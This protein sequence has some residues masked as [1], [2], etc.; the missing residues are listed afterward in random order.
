MKRTYVLHPFL[1]AAYS[2]F[3]VY[4]ANLNQIPPGDLLRP[5]A[6]V[7]VLAG[8]LLGLFYL[9]KHDWHQAGLM[10]SVSVMA[11]LYFGHTTE[12]ISEAHAYVSSKG[13][14][15]QMLAGWIA[16][17][18]IMGMNRT[19][20]LI[21][22]GPNLTFYINI[23][24]LFT[25]IVP[26]ILTASIVGRNLA[27]RM[28]ERKST[29]HL[30][31]PAAAA[32]STLPDIYYIIL[33][34]Y[35]RQ[36]VLQD[37]Y[38]FDNSDFIDWLKGQGFY[39]ADRSQSNYMRTMLSLSSSLNYSYIQDN[40]PGLNY[41]ISDN[42]VER[43]LH[44]SGYATYEISSVVY[45]TQMENADRFYAPPSGNYI[46]PFE[47]VL[48]LQ[49]VFSPLFPQANVAPSYNY[50]RQLIRY[51]FDELPRVTT[52]DGGPKFVFAHILVPHPPFAFHAD[53]SSLTPDRPY[54][55]RDGKDFQGGTEEY[56]QGYTEQV[57][58]ANNQIRTVIEAIIQNS[59]RPLVIV[60]QGD[61]GGGAYSDFN[62]LGNNRCFFDRF[63]IL[64]AYYFSPGPG[65]DKAL[66]QLTPDVTPV[67]SFRIIFNAYLGAHLDLLVS[68]QYFSTA[69]DYLH[70]TDVTTQANQACQK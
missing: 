23:A 25:L 47:N 54:S 36:D 28:A 7:L 26:L 3:G 42:M 61:H 33:D 37:L 44:D 63:A 17:I 27:G 43:V 29:A 14:T 1:F 38:G 64:N 46:T 49:S 13:L 57:Q 62:N 32:P 15:Y 4:S 69:A 18:Y 39:V 45:F 9:I 24:G 20:K 16:A 19:W 66:A 52:E 41:M 68:R 60:L 50:H 56:I 48:F 58:F 10:A 8:L 59:Q 51:A 12:V 6:V 53:G 40:E 22:G 35:G 65:R 55:I 21:R 30:F 34:G 5:L 2:V 67:N 11:I 31:V 70:L